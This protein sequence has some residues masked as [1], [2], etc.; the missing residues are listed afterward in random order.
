MEI[1]VGQ[2]CQSG[3]VKTMRSY[4]KGFEFIGILITI[5][6]YFRATVGIHNSYPVAKHIVNLLRDP[7][8]IVTC[9]SND[10]MSSFI[11]FT[12][13]I[14]FNIQFVQSR[15]NYEQSTT[16]RTTILV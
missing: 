7:E 15:G 13:E 1:F 6:L 9:R 5:L 10:S 16:A 2:W 8:I 12:F 14:S 3:I 11:T 4:G